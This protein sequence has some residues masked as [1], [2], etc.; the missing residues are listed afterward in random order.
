VSRRS[1]R[2]RAGDPVWSLRLTRDGWIRRSV[3]KV[4]REDFDAQVWIE[5]DPPTVWERQHEGH[6]LRMLIKGVRERNGPW[7]LIEHEVV[8]SDGTVHPLG[9]TD[10]ADWSFAGDLLFAKNGVLYRASAGDL[11][12]PRAIVDLS[13]LTFTAREA[14][15][16][17]KRWPKR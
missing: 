10:W 3:G 5:M 11:A 6:T 12:T 17:A 9:R 13:S 1:A 7:Y 16:E 14:P 4:A 8:A 15:A 2:F